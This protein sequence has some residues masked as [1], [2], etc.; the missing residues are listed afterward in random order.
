[1]GKVNLDPYLFF[2]GNCE[3]AMNFYKGVFGGEL[4]IQ[5][6]DAYPEMPVE[7]SMK[8]KIMHAE[9]NNGEIRFFAS[10]SPKA[11]GQSAK[12]ELSLSG[13]D[14]K[15]LR[16]YWDALTGGG[17]VKFPLEKAPWGD[18]YGMLADKYGVD[19][20]VNITSPK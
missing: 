10:D 6:M 2:G 20:M 1:M 15:K 8:D 17:K 5:K 19:W 3:E 18:T 14:E 13:D 7:E 4:T 9:L 11:S 12:V 16:G